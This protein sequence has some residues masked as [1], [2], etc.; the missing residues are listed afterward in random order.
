MIYAAIITLCMTADLNS[1]QVLKHPETFTDEARCN[2]FVAVGL[3]N[4]S[5]DMPRFMEGYCVSFPVG[6][7]A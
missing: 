5:R 3:D 2:A 4:F 6:D 7:K 1:C